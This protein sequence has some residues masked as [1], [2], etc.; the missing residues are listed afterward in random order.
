MISK[1][2]KMAVIQ[3]ISGYGRCSMTVALPIISALKVQCC[4][5]PTSIF[6]NHTAWPHYFF[7]DYTDRLPEYLH[8]WKQ[9]KLSFDGI[10]SGF[11]GSREQIELVLGVIA[12]FWKESTIVVVDP[13]MGD[14]GKAY[15]TYTPAMC[16]EMK[17]L[18]AKADIITPNVTEAC[19]LMDTP[20]RE[21][22]WK[23]R[24]I[25]AM[26][27][28]LSDMGPKKVVITGICQGDFIANFVYEEGKMERFLRTHRAGKSRC[29]TGDVFA[30]VI[31][32]DAV[33]GV[34][35]DVSVKKASNFVK[36]CI[37]K[38]DEWNIPI[39]DGVC[40]EEELYRLVKS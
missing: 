33:Q 16:R 12:D 5:V 14:N 34:P 37:I 1:Q 32:A 7:D 23:N 3:D 25:R 9:L 13:V 6:S 28:A 29:G 26:A 27:S 22:K 4:P 30:S 17:R 19:I 10:Y 40:F 20:Y 18:V 38:S 2:K 35:F 31:A 11:L 15:A 21:G 39:T 24:E 36:N 8:H